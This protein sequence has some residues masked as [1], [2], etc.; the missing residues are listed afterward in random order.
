MAQPAH[1]RNKSAQKS[2]LKQVFW[3]L[4]S[5]QLALSL[6]GIV[7]GLQFVS[8]YEDSWCGG[9]ESIPHCAGCAILRPAPRNCT[10]TTQRSNKRDCSDV[11]APCWAMV[12]SNG[13]F[14]LEAATKEHCE[15]PWIVQWTSMFGPCSY[16][17]MSPLIWFRGTGF[18]LSRQSRKQ[19][20]T[21]DYWNKC[22]C[23]CASHMKVMTFWDAGWHDEGDQQ[24]LQLGSCQLAWLFFPRCIDCDVLPW[25]DSFCAAWLQCNSLQPARALEM[26]NERI[27]LAA[28]GGPWP[29]M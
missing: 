6:K 16:H 21:N 26:A 7:W 25:R 23:V 11:S 18:L 27:E 3:N 19:K 10:K 20:T 4:Q 8:L 13:E 2:I 14:Q 15:T 22:V 9:E 1:G 12:F 28:S 29:P 5:F 24:C 17:C